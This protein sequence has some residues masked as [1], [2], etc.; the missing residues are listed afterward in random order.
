MLTDTPRVMVNNQFKKSF[1]EKKK[2]KKQLMFWAVLSFTRLC[3]KLKRDDKFSQK[4]YGR[5]AA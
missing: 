1:F 5:V 3:L 4:A 2:K